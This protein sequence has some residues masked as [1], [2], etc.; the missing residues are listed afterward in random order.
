MGEESALSVSPH[1]FEGNAVLLHAFDPP[2]LKIT[3]APVVSDWVLESVRAARLETAAGST[4]V[5]Y[6]SDAGLNI[7][8]EP[9]GSGGT[10]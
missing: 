4:G 2:Q 10:V 7:G 8:V 3:C 9:I 6:V 1:P 5:E